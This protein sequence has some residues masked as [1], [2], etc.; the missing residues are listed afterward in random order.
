MIHINHEFSIFSTKN[1]TKRN[2]NKISEKDPYLKLILKNHALQLFISLETQFV[3]DVSIPRYFDPK[4][5]RIKTL[6]IF[7]E[8]TR[9][10]VYAA[11]FR[12]SKKKIDGSR[13]TC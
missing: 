1:W 11:S 12:S 3:W 8:E 2:W 9:K 6:Q 10:L 13:R 5:S 4:D 7:I